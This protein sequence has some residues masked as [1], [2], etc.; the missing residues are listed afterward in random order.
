MTVFLTC[1]TLASA[2]LAAFVAASLGR[3]EP[4]V[5]QEIHSF[6]LWNPVPSQ[7]SRGVHGVA[8]ALAVGVGARV[9]PD[10]KGCG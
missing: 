7:R 3:A 10:T 2:A 6:S 1:F 4:F 8:L 5:I 9:A